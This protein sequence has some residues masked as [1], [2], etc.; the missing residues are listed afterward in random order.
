VNVSPPNTPAVYGLVLAGG[1]SRR[2]G[3]DKAALEYAG[4]TQLARAMRLLAHLVER[5]FVSVRPDQRDDPER[6]GYDLIVDRVA[7]RGPMEG[8]QAAQSQ[9]P[10]AAWL[11]VACDLPFLTGAT[12]QQLLAMRAPLRSATAFRSHHDGRPEPLCA[13]YE[14][15]SREA[16]DRWIAA[17]RSCPRGYLEAGD[18]ELLDL[19]EPE[20]LD[21]V[22]T[23]AEYAAAHGALQAPAVAASAG[24]EPRRIDVRYF[25]ILREQA[26]R[27]E[28]TLQSTARTVRDLYAELRGTR[29]LKLPVE[30]LRVA[31]NSEF[32]DWNRA[33][34]TGDT[35]VFLP[36]VAGG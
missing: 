14:P 36:P 2:M 27:S 34:R 10:S 20:A 5:T 22:N 12:L 13:I 7:D 11:V 17:G 6:A 32:S 4:E 29:G 33:L 25:A 9:Y 26:G 15:A 8:I 21:N 18:V 23:A 16:L 31:V 24:E 30:L 19:A 3:R 28:E 35:V 1:R